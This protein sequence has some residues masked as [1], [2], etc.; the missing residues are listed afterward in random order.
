LFAPVRDLGLIVVDEE[1]EQSYKQFD[2][3]P[4]YHARDVAIVKASRH[5]AVIVLGS[6]TPSIE[7]YHNAQS[8]KYTLLTLPIRAD[9]ARLPP[10]TIV[11]MVEERKR[12]Y[13][14]MKQRAKEIG[15][16]AF[17]GAS[18]SISD[19]LESKIRDRLNRHEGI[20]ILQNRRGFAPF[21]ECEDCGEVQRCNHCS[22]TLT[23]HAPQKHL[24]CHYCGR[25]S[26]PP[27]TC[28]L[29]G[30]HALILRG[31]GTQ[32]VEEELSGLFPEAVIVRMDLD[33]TTARQSH[34]KILRQFGEG[35]ADILLGTQMVAKGL[36]FPRVTLVGVI[37]A[38]TQMMLPD[39]RSAERTFQLL[40]QVAGR[41]G[42]STLEGEVIIQTS[43]PDHYAL[44]H[45]KDHDFKGFYNEELSYRSGLHYPPFSRI[46][47][48]ELKGSNERRVETCA[49]SLGESLTS[50]LGPAPILGPSPAVIS[51]IKNEYRWQV[52]VKAEKTSDVNATVARR[53]VA[54]AVGRL[55]ESS[56]ANGVRI[57]IDVDPVG[58]I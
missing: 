31:F 38:D 40:T 53:T 19:L 48:V 2:A 21:L 46:I 8:C 13:E 55:R 15:K 23:Y 18:R 3:V 1:H 51:R 54:Q 25:V 32:R 47:L 50:A 14:A 11:S 58:I 52:I 20:I 24:R 49:L 39:F 43:Q 57:G 36:D 35:R 6:A 4:R 33:T 5:Q 45:V 28:P 7:S 41:A 29:C 12:R 42:R 17:A 10:V 22:V 37:S 34:E 26:A 44:A 27:T 30:G 16:A 9:N 56:A